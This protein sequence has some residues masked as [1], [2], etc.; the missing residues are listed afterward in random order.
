MGSN[1]DIGG[2]FEGV[3][4]SPARTRPAQRAPIPPRP[5][6]GV[7]KERWEAYYVAA[8][9][10]SDTCAVS[11]S[12]LVG[13][14]LGLGTHVPWLGDVTPGVGVVAGLLVLVFLYLCRAWDP[15]VLGQGSDEFSRLM[16]AILS[17]AVALG[18]LGLAGQ[19]LAARPWVFGLIPLAGVL[20]ALGRLLLR[21]QIRRL[22]ARGRC[23]LPVLAVGNV[24]SVGD[25]IERIRRDEQRGWVVVGAC[26]PTGAAPDGSDS[27]DGVPVVGDLDA[28]AEVAR[29]G[30]H[31]IVAVCPAPGWSPARLHQLAWNLEDLTAELVVDPGLM[32]VAGPRLHVDPV[33]GLPLLRL[34]RPTFTGVAWIAKHVVDRFGAVLLLLALAPLLVTVAV[35]VKLDGGPILFKQTRVGR[36]GREFTMFKFRSMVVDAERRLAALTADNEG[37]GPLFKL[38][39]DPR[40][41]RVGGVLRRFSLDEL[42]QLFNV[43]NGT[44]SLV[45]PRP[46]LPVEV[47]S[48]G[49]AAQ[50]RLLVRPGLTGLWQISGRSDL[51]WEQSVR[52]DLRY[53]ENW[54]LALD[55][56]I[57]WK[58]L[59]AVI[60]RRG[61]Y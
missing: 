2:S 9:I 42:P 61:A 46:P 37:A 29:E 26:V 39:K 11:I 55:A 56:R 7:V 18:L 1:V 51:T 19:A 30:A 53:V 10:A 17:A 44:M 50:R 23:A 59:G 49:R 16:R 33:D 41:T 14:V 13:Y 45:G 48:Y 8:T 58:T 15:R 40:I 32:D 28:V 27:I 20:A 25:L 54:N 5:R 3:Q 38:R 4:A 60:S 21:S 24:E 47:A 12:I 22:R 36:H 52:L 6:A 43:L 31:R 34:T 57:L 35:A